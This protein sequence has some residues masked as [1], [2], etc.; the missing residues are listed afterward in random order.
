MN[1]NGLVYHVGGRKSARKPTSTHVGLMN[2]QAH[3]PD[4]DRQTQKELLFHAI[5]PFENPPGFEPGSGSCPF[6]VVHPR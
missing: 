6:P 4:E 5:P 1:I 2:V 3:Q